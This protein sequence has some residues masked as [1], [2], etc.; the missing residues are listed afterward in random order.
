MTRMRAPMWLVSEPSPRPA[1]VPAPN[2]A[3]W[4]TSLPLARGAGAR[5][6]LFCLGLLRGLDAHLGGA[7]LP[8]LPAVLGVARHALEARREA[9]DGPEREQPHDDLS[10]VHD[11]LLE[12]S[13]CR[14]RSDVDRLTV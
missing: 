1:G 9:P 8:V 5:G 4:A 10:L 7:L 3:A 13:W 14:A 6:A 2:D 12:F 11:V